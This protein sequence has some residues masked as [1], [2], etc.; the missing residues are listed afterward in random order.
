VKKDI[1]ASLPLS[2]GVRVLGEHPAGLVALE[3]PVGTRSHP[4]RSGADKKALLVAPYD[5][6]KE[7]FR[8]TDSKSGR[9][10]FFYLAHRLDGPTSGV[11]LGC[12]NGELADLVKREFLAGRVRKIYHAVAKAGSGARPGTVWRDRLSKVPGHSGLKVVRGRGGDLA[13]TRVLRCRQGRAEAGL[14][15]LELAPETGRTHQIRVQCAL[16]GTPVAGDRTY[17]DFGFNRRVAALTGHKRLFL[18]AARI[19]IAPKFRGERI[20]FEVTSP[21]PREFAD[22]L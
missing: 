8:W 9:E 2:D 19:A 17:G 5:A 4:N 6:E 10:G 7:C 13:I 16:R 12:V 1:P 20:E 14:A 11:I 15:L 3:K 22:L 18:H 21:R